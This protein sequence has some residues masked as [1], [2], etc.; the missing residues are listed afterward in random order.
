METLVF[1]IYGEFAHFRSYDTTRE[2]M[3]YPFPPRTAIIGLIGGILGLER[4]TYWVDSPIKDANIAI[5]ILSPIWRSSIRVNYLHTK[6]PIVLPSSIKILMAKDPFDVN[7]KGSRGFNAPVNINILRSVK[8]R[9]FFSSKDEDLMKQLLN[10]LINRKYCFPPYLGHANMLAEINFIGKVNATLLEKGE[11]EVHSLIPV[12][13]LDTLSLSLDDLGFT[14]IFNVPIAL[15]F[16]NGRLFLKKSDHIILNSMFEER[17]L[18]CYFKANKLFQT[19]INGEIC[20]FTF[21]ER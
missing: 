13:A 19:K 4:N 21:L 6:Y 1:D 14:I 5:Q 18:I 11:Y 16:E 12:S 3:S 8:Y 7:K 10:R 17:K 15:G 2:N 20:N 9:I